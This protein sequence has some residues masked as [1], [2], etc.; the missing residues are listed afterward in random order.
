MMFLFGKIGSS[1]TEIQKHEFHVIK[2]SERGRTTDL[3]SVRELDYSVHSPLHNV[4]PHCVHIFSN[5]P[6]QK[7]FDHLTCLVNVVVMTTE[8]SNDLPVANY[9]WVLWSCLKFMTQPLAHLLYKG[10]LFS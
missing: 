6:V 2:G 7:F 9:L 10:L 8:K 4:V 5:S 3:F 1:G